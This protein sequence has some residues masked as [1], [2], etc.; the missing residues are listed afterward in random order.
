MTVLRAEMKPY[1]DPSGP[2]T[3]QMLR[4]APM[5]DP[6]GPFDGQ[7][8]S[9]GEVLISMDVHAAGYKLRRVRGFNSISF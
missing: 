1:R 3:F 6:L 8:S 2:R 5:V 9:G 7:G 4:E